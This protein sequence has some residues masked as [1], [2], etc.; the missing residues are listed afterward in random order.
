MT[1][2]LITGAT[3]FLGGAFAARVLSA[4]PDVHLIAT[5]RAATSAAARLRVER[6]L[7]KFGVAAPECH[8]EVVAVDLAEPGATRVLP[9][10]RVTHVAHFASDPTTGS[11]RGLN[12]AGTIALAQGA[13]ER[14]SLRRFLYVGSAWSCG[15]PRSGLVGED[16]V[17]EPPHLFPYLAAKLVTEQQLG[18]V[19]GSRLQIVRPSLVLGHTTLGCAPSASLLWL[20]RLIDQVRSIPWPSDQRLDIVPVDWLAAAIDRVLLSD[21]IS[22]PQRLHLSAGPSSTTWSTIE[23]VFTSRRDGEGGWSRNVL[24]HAEW[25]EHAKLSLGGT[26]TTSDVLERCLRFVSGN[27]AFDNQRAVAAGLASPPGLET[28]L[29]RCLAQV[30][31]RSI[32]EQAL[33]DA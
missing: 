3:G 27:A 29:G 33:D 26:A 1:T 5:A 15:T 8:V 30:R 7:R 31:G 14:G 23:R 16:A 10:E 18:E 4:H 11:E 32:A 20:L 17:V 2:V 12:V 9:M 25:V 22:L 13:A 19:L 28:Y 24:S 6:A 21:S